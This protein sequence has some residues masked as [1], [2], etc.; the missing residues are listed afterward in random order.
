MFLKIQHSHRF[1]S[2]EAGISTDYKSA[3]SGC[4]TGTMVN[5]RFS[6]SFLGSSTESLRQLKSFCNLLHFA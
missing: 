2:E 4:A 1:G 3:R 6:L 5:R